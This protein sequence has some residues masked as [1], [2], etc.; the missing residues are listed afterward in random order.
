MGKTG[1]RGLLIASYK[2]LKKVS[3]RAVTPAAEAVQSVSLHTG[4]ARVPTSQEAAPP[5]RSIVTRAELSQAKRSLASM[6]AGM[7]Q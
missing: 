7:F 5:S 2:G 4:A 3:D 6:R 1:Q